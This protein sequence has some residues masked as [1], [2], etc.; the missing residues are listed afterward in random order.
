MNSLAR[1]RRRG[2]R[3]AAPRFWTMTASRYQD[4]QA[5]DIP[6]ITEADATRVRV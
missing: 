6:E 3:A 2:Q 5:R 4:I 1:S